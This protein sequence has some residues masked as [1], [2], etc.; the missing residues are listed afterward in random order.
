M[1]LISVQVSDY[2]CVRDAC[3]FDVSDITCLVGKNESGKT[4]I[5][6]AIYKLNP[7][8]EEHGSFDV[9][10]DFP[11]VDVEDYRLRVAT[12]ERQPALVVRAGYRLEPDD[13]KELELDFPGLMTEP[14]LTLSKGYSNEVSVEM[15][16]T[17]E[18]V[19]ESLLRSASAATP[20]PRALARCTTLD[21]LSA[22]LKAYE[23][24]E[25]VRKL[26]SLIAGIKKEGLAAY[27]YGHYLSGKLPKFLYF[28]EFYQMEGHVNID[29]LIKR[30]R[31]KQLLDSDHPLLGLIALAR[32]DL[33]EICN[34]KRAL[35]R[36]NRLEGASNHLTRNVMKYWSQNPSL[37]MRFD[38][39]PALPND[40]PGMQ[41][42]TNLWG[43]VYN[44][45]QRITTLLGRRSRGFVWFYSFLAWFSQHKLSDTPLIVLLDEPATHLHGSGQRDLLRYLEDE[46]SSGL[47]VIYTT[48]SPYMIDPK[49]LDRVRI[50]E[51][52]SVE[53]P[54][55][56]F[57]SARRQ[58]TQVYRDVAQATA[59]SKLPL[60][61]AL[62]H[63]VLEGFSPGP[64]IL[65]VEGVSDLIYLRAVS[66]LLPQGGLDPRWKITPVD[67][68]SRIA[69]FTGLTGRMAD[70]ILAGVFSLHDAEG[71]AVPADGDV[72]EKE[73]FFSYERFA[74][75]PAADIEDLFDPEFYLDIV[76][77]VYAEV[78][79]KPLTPGLLRP[80]RL[81]IAER[82]TQYCLKHP[83]TDAVVFSRERPAMHFVENVTSLA[84]RVSKDTLG[85]FQKLFAALNA[86]L[87]AQPRG[88]EQEE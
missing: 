73:R 21:E 59:E 12:G 85:R 25:P 44:S 43:H 36:D 34:P 50:V 75:L 62:G 76:N 61:G 35:Q 70:R 13:L 72:L 18:A 64:C 4:T 55:F 81:K 1:K 2:K 45:K 29:A 80:K 49:R 5:L 39:R 38:I 84:G 53:D 30:R 17:E 23:Q 8:V 60:L 33:D 42:G 65:L 48:Q 6:E 16:V 74:N 88:E 66:A 15:P 57:S 31:E 68:A 83:L 37:E 7:V 3:S 27:L 24:E 79:P 47:Q 77:T 56:T 28:D 32:L 19:V 63:R 10:D 52:R 78:L 40:P 26:Q 86:L 54:E 46:C 11:R 58:G 51:D 22:A 14:R 41:G 69:V 82:I 67:G 87:P 9:D 71:A 20:K